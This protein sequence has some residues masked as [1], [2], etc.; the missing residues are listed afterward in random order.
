MEGYENSKAALFE[1]TYGS[2]YLN[3][4]ILSENHLL[5]DTVKFLEVTGGTLV[6]NHLTYTKNIHS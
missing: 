6:S 5:D 3:N 4:L 1:T 2:L